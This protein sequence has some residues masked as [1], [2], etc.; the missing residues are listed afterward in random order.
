LRP[1]CKLTKFDSSRLKTTLARCSRGRAA[2]PS[3]FFF[4]VGAV[5]PP[6][7]PAPKF[8]DPARPNHRSLVP[9]SQINTNARSNRPRKSRTLV[10]LLLRRRT[11]HR[12]PG[13]ERTPLPRVAR[14]RPGVVASSCASCCAAAPLAGP[15]ADAASSS[16]AAVSRRHPTHLPRRRGLQTHAVTARRFLELHDGVPASSYICPSCCLPCSNGSPATSWGCF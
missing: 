4:T 7:Y 9:P 13:Q 14:R 3:V 2:P 16:C 5:Y 12:S 1:T 6:A 8:T 15:R 11:T 10:P